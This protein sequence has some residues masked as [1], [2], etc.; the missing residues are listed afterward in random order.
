MMILAD[1]FVPDFE[2]QSG[3]GDMSW[4]GNMSAAQVSVGNG[5][6]EDEYR[7]RVQ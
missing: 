6:H 4:G 5:I 7:S 2:E 3:L 1:S